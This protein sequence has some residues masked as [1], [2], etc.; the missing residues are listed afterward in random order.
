M[1]K[2]NV[3][4]CFENSGKEKQNSLSSGIRITLG[5]NLRTVKYQFVR[6]KEIEYATDF[7]FFIR[8][9]VHVIHH[10]DNTTSICSS[11][12]KRCFNREIISPSDD[13]TIMEKLSQIHSDIVAFKYGG[14]PVY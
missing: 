9:Q 11:L 7:D 1:E 6:I 13:D 5:G 4:N 12:E 14:E 8:N 2:K 3:N 10:I